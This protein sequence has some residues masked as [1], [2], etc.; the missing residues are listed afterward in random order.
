MNIVLWIVQIFLGLLFLFA[1]ASKFF[2]SADDLAK[3]MPSMSM[4]FLYFIGVCEFLGGIGL[5]VPWATKIK[6]WLTPL[7]AVLLASIMIG[8]VV[9][10]APM[11]VKNAIFPAIAGLLLVFV[12]WG[13][14][15]GA[16][17]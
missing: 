4:G 17:S 7:A 15:G 5:I 6:P 16:T 3:N 10:T 8:A 12:A 11:G 2:M 13:R 9:V 1:G 14:R